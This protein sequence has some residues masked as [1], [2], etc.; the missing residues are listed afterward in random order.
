GYEEWGD[1][2]PKRLN[3]MFAFVVYDAV[4]K[5]LFLARDRFGEKPLYYSLQNGAFAFASELTALAAHSALDFRIDSLGLQKFLAYGFTPAPNT[6]YR[7]CRKLPAGHSLTFDLRERSI[8]LRCYWQL[9]LKPDESLT[10]RDEPRLAEELR[11]LIFEAVRRRLISDVPLGCFLSG[12]VDSSA[13]VA[14]AVRCR[15]ASSLDTFTIGF[16]DPSF[17]ESAQARAA[18]GFFGTRHHEQ[19]LDLE[20]ARNLIAPVLERL[21]EPLGDASILP[22]FL[23]SRFARQEV[24]VV[25]TGD[26]GD[27]LFAGYDPFK[28]LLPARIYAALVPRSLNRG[29]RRLAELLP[30]SRR[31]MSLDFKLRRFLMGMS[32]P[33]ACWNP[34]WL[35]PFDPG[36]MAELLN[37]AVSVQDVYSEAL[38]CWESN[39]D[40]NFLDRTLAFYTRFYLQDDVLMKVDRAAMMNGLEGRAAFLDNDLV[41]FCERLPTRFKFAGGR[42]KKLLRRAL[43]GIVPKAVLDRPKKGFGVPISSWL[44]ELSPPIGGQPEEFRP[45]TLERLWRDHASGDADHRLSIWSCLSLHHHFAGMQLA[46][47]LDPL[48][49]VA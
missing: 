39:S 34:V 23:V 19:I 15:P 25:L 7:D 45:G 16:T 41:A 5:R 27:E 46:R 9:S 6:I 14:A 11:A 49:D 47:S 32:Y 22:T 48:P 33:A 44:R 43:E 1:E 18:A 26:G 24:T 40:S 30:I 35:A 8:N 29:F 2:L 36:D 3:G 4:R 17:D 28:A 31:N 21:D 10:A 38:E 13:V 12:G 20:A 42:G 37:E